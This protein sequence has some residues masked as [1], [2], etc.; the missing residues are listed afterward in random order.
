M[1][2]DTSLTATSG[3]IVIT[4]DADVSLEDLIGAA[5]LSVTSG[6]ILTTMGAA[7]ITGATTIEAAAATM[8]TAS[9][10][11]AASLEGT[12]TNDTVLDQL[13]TTG[14][15]TVTVSAGTL[16]LNDIISV[17][18]ALALIAEG[19]T[20]NADISAASGVI[21]AG[22]GPFTMAVGTSLTATSLWV[23]LSSPVTPTFHWKTSPVLQILV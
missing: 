22:S 7:N 8:D 6:G 20:Q 16:T 12:F 15:T 17:D 10:L 19:C 9:S 5:N 18:D 23:I 13:T 11:S 3:D 21:T 14:N 1:A 2:T 4:S